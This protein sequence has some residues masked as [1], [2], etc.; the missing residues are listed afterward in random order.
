VNPG[1]VAGDQVVGE[2]DVLLTEIDAH[3]R[4]SFV[5]ARAWHGL[6]PF[7]TFGGGLVMDVAD[8]PQ[9]EAGL[10][11]ADVFDFGTSFIG[12]AGLG[13]RWF[14]TDRFALRFDGSF[15]LWSVDTPPGFSDP[16]RGFENV[17][18]SEWLSG[19][20]FGVALLYRW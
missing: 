16:T 9:E 12:T 3:L 17:E 18:E 8:A 20:S 19:L 6:S 11:A 7:L 2:G 13:T 5:G 15:S 14:L 10:E 1:R 4:F